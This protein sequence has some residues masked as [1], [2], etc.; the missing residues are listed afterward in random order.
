MPQQPQSSGLST[1]ARQGT[2]TPQHDGPVSDTPRRDEVIGSLRE[3]LATLGRQMDELHTQKT[4]LEGVIRGKIK[5]LADLR[6]MQESISQD[7]ENSRKELQNQSTARGSLEKANEEH[8]KKLSEAQS[9]SETLRSERD[10]LSAQMIIMESRV[11]AL[12]DVQEA[13]S[14]NRVETEALQAEKSKLEEEKMAMEAKLRESLSM[15]QSET[16]ALRTEE[17][18]LEDGHGIGSTSTDYSVGSGQNGTRIWP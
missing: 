12:D 17:S 3:E 2:A 16:E 7:L 8:E 13:A 9:E 10:R 5:E 18:K 4:T 6:D 11:K 1:G 15:A 14:T